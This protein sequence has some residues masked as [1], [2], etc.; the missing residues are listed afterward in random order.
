M[1]LI[2]G[3]V[4]QITQIT[5]IAIRQPSVESMLSYGINLNLRNP[6]SAAN[7]ICDICGIR[8]ICESLGSAATSIREDTAR[9]VICVIRVICETFPEILLFNLR[10]ICVSAESA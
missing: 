4:S 1:R 6:M 8:V 2:S 7:Q 3:K 10:E 5:Q 9:M